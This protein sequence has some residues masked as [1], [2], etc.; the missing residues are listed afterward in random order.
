MPASP[1][2]RYP[3][4]TLLSALLLAA[5][6]GSGGGGESPPT[7]PPDLAGV[8][9]GTWQGIDPALGQ[10]GGTF[11]AELTQTDSTLTG[12]V[13]LLGDVD[14]IAGNASGGRDA[15][16]HLSGTLDR[17][18]CQLNQWMLTAVNTD[19]ET[20][21]GSWT[22]SGSGA[23]GTLL[24]RR[25]ARLGG[26]RVVSV[27]P[28]AASAGAVITI[29]G[30]SLAPPAPSAPLT[31]N[32]T[33]QNALLSASATRWVARVPAG[34]GT[35][36]IKVVTSTGSALGPV[37]F[38]VAVSSPYPS[39]S[40]GWIQL[41]MALA[42]T[43]LAFSTD[44][45]KL[46]VAQRGAPDGAVAVVH[47]LAQQV[48][49]STVVSQ[50]TPLAIAVAPAGKLIYVTATGKGVLVLDAALANLRDTI[51]V[52]VGDGTFDNP[53][54]IA[55][56]PDGTLLLVSDGTP[57]GGASVVRVA[58]KT[59]AA[60]LA[61]PADRAP[62]GVAFSRDGDNAYV[63]A[64]APAGGAGEVL[65]FDVAT[66]TRRATIQV[67]A[68]PTGIAVSP[69]GGS[70]FVSNQADNTVSHINAASDTVSATVP[71]AQAP[72]GIAISPDGTRVFVA[73]RVGNA[74]SV[75]SSAD[76]TAAA[77][78]IALAD[79][80]LAVAIDAQGHAA[81]VALGAAAAVREIGGSRALDIR[82]SGTGYGTVTSSP[83]GISCGTACLSRFAAGTVVTLTATPDDNSN[84]VNWSGDAAC[85]SGVVTLN[86][87]TSCVANFISKTSVPSSG[88]CFIA[89]AAYG[90]AMAPEVQSLRQFRDRYLLTHAPG[91]AFVDFYYRIS[92]PLAETIRA[93]EYARTAVR[94]VLWPVVFAV[95][96]P[97]AALVLMLAAA[98]GLTVQ[99]RLPRSLRLR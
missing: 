28:P 57:G 68:R 99:R 39:L 13:T 66:G 82:I 47:A 23:S 72:T 75:L 36:W 12:P 16:D 59:L 55:I 9:A 42:P 90:S 29:A 54:G 15:Q 94:M 96:H 14:C 41:P 3:L 33:A 86:A 11:E 88:A 87:N 84:F 22:Q 79:S 97:V 73:S 20:A 92:P 93:N 67:G 70:I 27:H 10:V 53:H 77:P 89:T 95:N 38:G 18:P 80:P 49:A 64:A 76:G 7:P 37:M 44:S 51:A 4:A 78:P 6:C 63:L 60:H 46:F 34:A 43:A 21:T 8:W 26:P 32:Q 52:P 58:D 19:A 85:A 17:T 91:R 65:R 1:A 30:Q 61:L 25:V 62:L 24:G 74:V 81:Y 35:G 71:V 31:F 45:R 48:L 2:H 83:P 69:D 50:G 40:P 5:G 56:S 98:A